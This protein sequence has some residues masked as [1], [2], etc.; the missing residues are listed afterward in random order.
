MKGEQLALSVQLRSTASF[1]TYFAGPNAPV[2][3]A[4]RG[5]A[6]APAG[7]SLLFGPDGVGKTHLLQATARA[8]QQRGLRVV[9]LPL[10]NFGDA[11]P[12]ETVDGID[13]L[14]LLALDDIDAVAADPD[15]AFALIRLIDRLRSEQ[16]RWLISAAAAPERITCALPDLRTRLEQAARYGLRTLADADRS[17]WLRDNAQARG[18]ELPDEVAR[19]LINHL[20]RDAASLVAALERLDRASLSAKRRLTLPFVQKTLG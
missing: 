12:A 13:T 19:W 5:I 8:A 7:G 18:L 11:D 3:A 6:D 17:Q 15:W 4:L 10:G 14:D 1:D 2:V 9:Y 16:R 20:P